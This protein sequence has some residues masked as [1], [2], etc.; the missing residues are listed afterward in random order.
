MSQSNWHMLPKPNDKVVKQLV[1]Q[2]NISQLS[3]MIVAQKG[4]DSPEAAFQYLKPSMSTLHDPMVLHD[5]AATIERLQEAAF[6]GEKIVVYGDY[7]MD[8]V[9]STAIMVEALEVLGADVTAYIPNRFSDGYGPNVAAYQKLIADGAQLIVT[10]DNGV[11]GN[12]AVEYAMAQG[13]D[14]I[15]TDHHELPATLPKAFAIVHPRHP[16]GNYPFGDLSGAGVA[17]KVAQ[18]LLSD[19]QTATD[20]SELPTE[21]LDLVALGELADMVSLTDENRVLVALG[22]QQINQAPRPG[23]SAILKNAGQKDN[24]PVISETVG[25]KIAPRINAVGRLG[26][27]DLSLKLL[28]S[29]DPEEAATLASEVEALNA[30]RQEIVEEVLGAAKQVALSEKYQQDKVVI[31]AG[32]S[33]HQG[34]LGIVA[35]RLVDI[36]H[37]PVIVLSLVDGIYKGSGRTFGDFDLY[38]LMNDYRY[39]YATFGG[40]KSA[41]GLA[42]T[43]DNLKKLIEQIRSQ[44]DQI[45]VK[46]EPIDVNLVLPPEAMTTEIYHDLQMMEPFGTDNPQ[47]V[48][49]L[50]SP[51]VVSAV[52]MGNAKQHIKLKL[53]NNVEVLGFNHPDWLPVV[54]QPNGHAMVGTLGLNYFRGKKTLQLLLLDVD[55]PVQKDDNEEH[56]RFFATLYKFIYHNQTLNFAENLDKIAKQFNISK[57][58]LNIMVQVFI[59]LDFVTVHDGF[60]KINP[61]AAQKSLTTSTTYQKYLAGR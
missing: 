22:L 19:G 37:K 36:L 3:A 38:Q 51:S 57:K 30:Q 4:Y 26:D 17:F 8:G 28:M 29:Q 53:Q 25:F 61:N 44:N 41:L 10:V 33:W 1:S 15:I 2:L 27:A 14:V 34:I 12:E 6:G 60:V 52:T 48:F 40:H 58:D 13:I 7:D 43:P 20:I 50:K 24:E 39:L 47:P 31:V 23:L 32:D 45:I 35:S 46:P 59:E 18:A 16:E 49:A 54:A 42:I 5:M 56:K 21:L 9:T 11:S 55:L